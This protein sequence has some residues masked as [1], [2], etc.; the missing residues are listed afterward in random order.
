MSCR[1]Q[2]LE[3]G[4]PLQ[5]VRIS[6]PSPDVGEVQVRIKA[7]GLNPIDWKQLEYGIN[8][9]SW[10][11]AFGNEAS[12]VVE[13]IGSGVSQFT[14]GDDVLARFEPSVAASAAFQTVANI[15]ATQVALKPASMSFEQAASIPMGFMTAASTIYHGLGIPLLS[16]TMPGIEYSVPSSILVLGGS[17]AVG[18]AVIQLLHLTLP[19]AVIIATSSSKHHAHLKA[20]GAAA[21][22]DYKSLQVAR[23]IMDNSPGGRGVD[24]IVDL[25][26]GVASNRELLQT[27]TGLKL[28]AELAAGDNA[29]E[30][31]PEIR[32]VV[33]FGRKV[34]GA[35]GASELFSALTGLLQSGS[36]TPPLPV[37][38]VAGGVGLSGISNGLKQL[39]AGVSG[40]KLV[41]I[42][43]TA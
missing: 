31:P 35:P 34:M 37:T 21:A 10:P 23:E 16:L 11:A 15:K 5:E 43:D 32:H 36:Y 33:T 6:V 26:N 18:A 24:A 7:V 41:A 8:V 28:F 29:Q 19:S 9:S 2:A 42:I 30:V 1:L 14:V 39:K 17:S 25:V 40:T 22:V 4:G 38:R 27:L 20:L 3:V 13:R 12:G